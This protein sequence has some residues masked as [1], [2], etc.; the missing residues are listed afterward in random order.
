VG[1]NFYYRIYK[2]TTLEKSIRND[3]ALQKNLSRVYS[4]EEN[5]LK[6][7]FFSKYEQHD[8]EDLTAGDDLFHIAGVKPGVN[9]QL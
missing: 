4:E 9:Y 8:I 7:I 3:P 2:N 6:P 5:F 1:V